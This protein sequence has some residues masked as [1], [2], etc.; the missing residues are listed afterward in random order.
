MDPTCEIIE[1]EA[2]P[3]L[4][5]RAKVS[6]ANIPAALGQGFSAVMQYLQELGEQPAGVPYVQYHNIDMQNLELEIG[7][8]VARDLPGRD[9]VQPNRMPAGEYLSCIHTGSYQSLNQTYDA[10]AHWLQAN[11]RQATGKVYEFYLND[12]GEVA[13]E[14]IKT[15]VLMPLQN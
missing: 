15:Q 1:R 3:V 5:T 6:A 13:E 10:M 7:F 12:P 4:T 9:D 2:Q 8:E 14:E 11:Q